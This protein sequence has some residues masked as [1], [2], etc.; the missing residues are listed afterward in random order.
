[1]KLFFPH[2]GLDVHC[3]DGCALCAP[4]QAVCMSCS[5]IPNCS[6]AALLIDYDA[7]HGVWGGMREREVKMYVREIKKFRREE[8]QNGSDN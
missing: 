5:V 2:D 4:A 3:K 1:M 6:A 7:V 8:Q